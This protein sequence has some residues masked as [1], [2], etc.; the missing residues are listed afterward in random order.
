M[1]SPL[2]GPVSTPACHPITG[3]FAAVAWAIV[4]ACSVGSNPPRMI[5]AGRD[6]IA[7]FIASRLPCGLP[8]PS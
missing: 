3:I 7:W 8:C 4:E 6:V 2:P 5:A 1:N